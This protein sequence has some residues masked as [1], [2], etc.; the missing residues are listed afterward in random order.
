[1]LLYYKVFES[2]I[3]SYLLVLGGG[4][5]VVST[6]STSFLHFRVMDWLM[7]QGFV[8]LDTS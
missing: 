4:C 2:V 8:A 3:Y 6:L 1:M 5:F 7:S